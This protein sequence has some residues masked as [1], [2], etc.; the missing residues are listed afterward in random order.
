VG[1]EIEKILLM[2][3][4]LL[5]VVGILFGLG[6]VAPWLFVAAAVLLVVWF[7]GWVVRVGG[8]RWFYW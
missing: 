8:G 5:L 2:A 4:L 1:I 7:T 3:L 6:F